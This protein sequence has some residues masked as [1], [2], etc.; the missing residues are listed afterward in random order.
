[1]TVLLKLPQEPFQTN[2]AWNKETSSTEW[3]CGY[4]G[5]PL[6]TMC[7]AFWADPCREFQTKHFGRVVLDGYNLAEYCLWRASLTVAEGRQWDGFIQTLTPVPASV[8]QL[9]AFRFAHEP[10]YK[11]AASNPAETQPAEPTP[12]SQRG[13]NMIV[14]ELEQPPSTQP[15]LPTTREANDAST[16]GATP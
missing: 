12:H 3:S 13:A 14:L 10:P 1:M 6:P 5:S 7:Y 8:E 2:G 11:P 15:G 9:K 4:R 16:Q